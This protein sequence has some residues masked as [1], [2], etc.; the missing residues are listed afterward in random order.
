MKKV[1][2]DRA[3]EHYETSHVDKTTGEVFRLKPEYTTMSRRPGIG[4]NWFKKYHTDVFPSDT[5]I[6]NGKHSRPPKFY[7]YQFELKDPSAHAL[8]KDERVRKGRKHR[9]N[10]TPERLDVRERCTIAKLQQ[11]HRDKI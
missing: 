5:V 1:T 9:A 10:N 4:S 7:D 11:L 2:G 3:L 6:S 8:I